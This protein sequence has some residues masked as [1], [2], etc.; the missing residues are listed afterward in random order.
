M[1]P[2]KYDVCMLLENS[3]RND[4]RV[5]KETR[6]LAHQGL[7]VILVA[8]RDPGT[9]TRE[10]IHGFHVQRLHV[11][12]RTLKGRWFL[13]LKIAE[14]T[15]RL[16]WSAL[17]SRARVYHAHHLVCLLPAIVAAKLRRAKVVYDVH[18]LRFALPEQ[19]PLRGKFVKWYEGALVRLVD[20]VIMSDG[21]SRTAVFRAAHNYR[22]PIE[23]VY[24]CAVDMNISANEHDLRK[25]LGIPD[26]ERVV[27]YTGLIGDFRG[28]EQ[29]IQSMSRWPS[30]S[31]FVM[32][33]TRTE[34]EERRLRVLA[35]DHGVEKRVHFWGPV[36]PDDVALWASRADISV[37]LIQ[38]ISL[39]YYYSAP[40][41]MFESIMARV[42][43]VSSDFP[44]ISRVVLENE[45]G[46][47]G[48]VVDPSD[49]EAVGRAIDELLRD[50][51]RRN[52]YRQNA[53]ALAR[54]SCN[55]QTQERVLVSMYR[56]MMV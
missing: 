17:A 18:E 14:F 55:W 31:H 34:A 46:P 33:G 30:R 20:R 54:S 6:S 37:V 26:S 41:K 10:S 45:V 4:A 3:F 40:T 25:E 28:L 49:A 56:E 52:T 11:W 16:T 48:V 32:I 9:K 1:G 22:K 21:A 51:E 12:S 47:V 35:I 38:N 5:L 42:P 24:N 44:E 13:V 8:L 50:D 19:G 39:S 29:T 27:V 7:A 15:A 36:P 43:Q 23:Y 2:S 53:D